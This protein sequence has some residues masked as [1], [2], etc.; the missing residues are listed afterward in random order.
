M[1]SRSSGEKRAIEET[2]ENIEM[3]KADIEKN[4]SDAAM[5]TKEIA[6][7]DD[8]LAAWTGDVKAATKVRAMEKTDCD[9]T[10][11]DYSESIDAFERAIAVLKKQAY[12]RK[13]ASFAQVKMPRRA[14]QLHCCSSQRLLTLLTRECNLKNGGVFGMLEV[15]ESDFAKL[16]ADT[17][18]A[19]ASAQKE[20]DTFMTDSKVDKAPKSTDIEHKTAKTKQDESQYL[21]V[22]NRRF[23]GHAEGTGC[24]SCILR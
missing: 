4:V 20:Y 6:G 16:K 13:Q 2:N 8:D 12:N 11:K 5:L 15:Q 14:K 24:C 19:E 9:A 10:H 3:L 23:R 22:N 7:L 21:T 18:A 17:K 1:T